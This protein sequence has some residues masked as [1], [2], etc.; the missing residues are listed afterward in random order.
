LDRRVGELAT[1]SGV[2]GMLTGIAGIII[3]IWDLQR[4]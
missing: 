3:G 4:S 2:V 1:I